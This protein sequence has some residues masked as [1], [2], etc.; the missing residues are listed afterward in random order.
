[1]AN[2]LEYVFCKDNRLVLI[3]EC[4]FVKASTANVSSWSSALFT[5]STSSFAYTQM[6]TQISFG[7]YSK[8][9]NFTKLYTIIC[10]VCWAKISHTHSGISETYFTS[11]KKEHNRS[12]LMNAINITMHLTNILSYTR[13]KYTNGCSRGISGELPSSDCGL[14]SSSSSP[15]G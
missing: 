11:C 4:L 9:G 14:I 10:R 13:P 3:M 7:S 12:P 5:G 15:Y 8:S 6:H 1:M 2:L